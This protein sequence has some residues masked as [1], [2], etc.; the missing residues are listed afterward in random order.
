VNA[1]PGVDMPDPDE[2]FH[3]R[4]YWIIGGVIVALVWIRPIASSLWTDEF[5]SWWVIKDGFRQAIDRSWTYQGQSPLYYLMVWA[6]RHATGDQEWALRL[7][8][9]ILAVLSVVLLYRLVR[10]LVDVEC[11]RIA[12]V[13]FVAWPIV[14]FSSIDFRPY[15]LATF[16][17]IAATL[18]SIRWLDGAGW[19]RG[20]VYVVLLVAAIWAH[21]LFGLIVIAHACYAIARLRDGTTKVRPRDLVVA[22]VGVVV[23]IAP[24]GRE[25]ADLWSRRDSVALPSGVSVDWVVSLL[26]PAALIGALIVGGGLAAVDGGRPAFRFRI[27]R[28]ALIL[29]VAW[30]VGPAAVLILGSLVSPLGLQGR[31]SLIWVPGA[32]VLAAVAIRA[33]EPATARRIIVLVLAVLSILALGGQN[34][35]GDWHGAMT[36]IDERASD[37]TVVLVQSG[38]VE[39][40]QLDWYGDPERVSYLGAPV[41][42]YPVPGRVVVVPV[43]VS[44][45]PDFTRDRILGSISGADSAMLVTTNATFATWVGEVLRDEGWVPQ[46]IV[47]DSPLVY[48]YAPP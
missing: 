30:V 29:L 39:S 43:D 18:A 33:I 17:A 20:V 46:Q 27:A 32:V 12:A 45:V 48:R 2:R 11:A 6:T 5:G 4:F 41:S 21:Y 42:Y 37:R 22:S 23:L 15:A 31:Y 7:P 3:R 8:S 25:L 9:V 16:L 38:Y 35:L 34:H 28:A 24:L 36:A 26:A 1:G 10:R 40:L 19:W 13:V 14:A 47:T 44:E